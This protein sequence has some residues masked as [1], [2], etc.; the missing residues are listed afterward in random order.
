ML[1]SLLV[2]CVLLFVECRIEALA[3]DLKTLVESRIEERMGGK[4]GLKID[5]ISGGIFHPFVL[6]GISVNGKDRIP[7][8]SSLVINN[9]RTDYYV[10]DIVKIRG[11]GFLDNL[12]PKDSRIYVNFVSKSNGVTGFVSLE[13]DIQE[14]KI[15]GYVI[16][17]DKSRVDFS[18]LVKGDLL[19]AVFKRGAVVFKAQL[20][21]SDEGMIVL[22]IKTNHLDLNGLDIVCDLVLKT[23][24]VKFSDDP[25]DMC[26]EGQ[27]ETKS[28]ILNYRPFFNIKSSYV[29]SDGVFALPD[30][31]IGEG[32][33]ARAKI[34]IQQPYYLDATLTANHVS[35][36]WLF[37]SMGVKDATSVISGIMNGKVEL[38]GPLAALK[39]DIDLDIKKGTLSTLDFE[40]LTAALKGDLPFLKIE[41]SRIT[42]NS[43]YFSL[44]GEMDLRKLGK[45]SLFAD[46]EIITDD[47]AITWDEW[48]AKKERGLN[49]ITMK[50]RLSEE[51]NLDFIKYISE[52]SVGESLKNADEVQLEYKL[53]PNDSLKMV[54]GQDK[55]F[56]G[57][58]HKDRF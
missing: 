21:V 42:R 25:A 5:H 47:K 18:G 41:E 14:P 29:Y 3:P 28:L 22:D 43:G 35:L 50:K 2:V 8:F 10:W 44:A 46:L 27:V 36:A 16:L 24:I 6:N 20:S 13:G 56:I 53:H 31:S 19:E 26:L 17:P 33:R 11:C 15:R 51:V 45:S 9:I 30:I 48:D 55:D 7:L 49:E 32:F 38:K 37:R 58:E 4:I 39:A 12:L 23:R 54:V 52:E 34:G 1:F 57:L 40:S